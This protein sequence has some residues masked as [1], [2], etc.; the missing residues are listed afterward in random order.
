MRDDCESHLSFSLF[1]GTSVFWFFLVFFSERQV[2]FV[3]QKTVHSTSTIWSQRSSHQVTSRILCGWRVLASCPKG[4]REATMSLTHSLLVQFHRKWLKPAIFYVS[5]LMISF[6]VGNSDSHVGLNPHLTNK[7]SQAVVGRFLVQWDQ[8]DPYLL[9]THKDDPE[10]IVFQTSSSWPFITIGYAT[11][12]NP[13]IVDGNYKVNE[14]TL[15]E[16]PYQS[17]K[18]VTVSDHEMTIAGDVWGMVTLAA[19]DLR[20][21]VPR[22]EAGD[23]LH[24][25]LAFNL[26]VHTPQQGTFNRVFLNYWCDQQEHFYG[27]GVQ[28]RNLIYVY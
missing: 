23:Y 19:Y 27:F 21:Y 12:A 9:I 22:N 8:I 10:K 15:Y 28:V 14:W 17:I 5:L 4:L 25:Q 18:K 24:N 26:T 1:N 7:L 2:V 16:T 20:F 6:Q 13:P 3:E 11:D